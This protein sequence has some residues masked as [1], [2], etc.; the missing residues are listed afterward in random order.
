MGVPEGPVESIPEE[1]DMVNMCNSL[2]ERLPSI[3]AGPS[4]RVLWCVHPLRP[5][6]LTLCCRAVAAG[7]TLLHFSP[8]LACTKQL[9]VICTLAADTT[10]AYFH[11]LPVSNLLISSLSAI[12]MTIL[13]RI[14]PSRLWH[15]LESFFRRPAAIA[16]SA[17]SSATVHQAQQP[18]S[19]SSIPPLANN[20]DS[21]PEATP[22]AEMKQSVVAKIAA[23][24]AAHAGRRPLIHFLGPRHP[25][26]HFDPSKLPPIHHAPAI[27]FLGHDR[28]QPHLFDPSKLGPVPH[29][30]S[31]SA[32]TSSIGKVGTTPRGSGIDEA[33]LPL[34]FRR[35]ELDQEEIDAINNGGAYGL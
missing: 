2:S 8:Q 30:S 32:S 9:V 28:Q 10:F 11:R 1:M 4:V 34:R 6:S 27:H 24:A 26:P 13:R 31:A 17:A 33:L 3:E 14:V 16:P 5:T 29:N 7:C 18:S 15:W 20:L 19:S 12:N 25:Q 23:A 21:K 35:R 22:T